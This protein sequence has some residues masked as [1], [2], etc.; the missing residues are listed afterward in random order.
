MGGETK[1]DLAY[2][3]KIKLCKFC[4]RRLPL[5]F[6]G[7]YCNDRCRFAYNKQKRYVIVK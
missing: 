7:L 1:Q 5:M 2:I 4:N 3:R 6:K